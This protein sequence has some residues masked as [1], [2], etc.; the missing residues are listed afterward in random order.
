MPYTTITA[1]PVMPREP[2][3]L[4]WRGGVGS[5]QPEYRMAVQRGSAPRD[6]KERK[7][8]ILLGCLLVCI[9]RTPTPRPPAGGGVGLLAWLGLAWPGMLWAADPTLP[10]RQFP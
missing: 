10:T 4:A 5:G 3:T 2:K 6:A 9:Q 8:E 1:A 7:R